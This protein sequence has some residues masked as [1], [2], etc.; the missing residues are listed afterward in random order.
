MRIFALQSQTSPLYQEAGDYTDDYRCGQP[1]QQQGLRMPP[2]SFEIAFL[3]R[4]LLVSTLLPEV[5]QQIHSLRARGVISCHTASAE[6]A[7]AIAFR[8]SLGI[9]CKEPARVSFLTMS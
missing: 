5:T 4:I 2:L 7:A 6:G 3:M 8:K 9:V 1:A